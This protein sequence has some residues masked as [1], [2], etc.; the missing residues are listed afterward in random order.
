MHGMTGQDVAELAQ[1]L[2]LL[3]T[4]L[5][6]LSGLWLIFRIKALFFLFALLA[7]VSIAV[8]TSLANGVSRDGA[9]TLSP[10]RAEEHVH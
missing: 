6:V 5:I 2:N 7:I 3:G 1:V 10:L 4:L 8:G 9:Q